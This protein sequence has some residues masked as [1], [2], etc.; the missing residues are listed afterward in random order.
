M[1]QAELTVG[2]VADRSGVPISTLHF[3]ERKGLIAPARDGSNRRLYPRE[4][5]RR[6]AVIKI[7]QRSGIP[8]SEIAD[9]LTTLP[10]ERTPTTSD[11]KRL[12]EKWHDRLSERIDALT[13]L[14]DKMS[15]CIGCGCLSVQRC[16]LMNEGDYLS[17][18]GPGARLLS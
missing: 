17:T 2:Q 12:S 10:R 1:M 11:W 9:A 16:P 13:A 8:L 6:V 5:L 7:A 14:R 4:I 15:M 3:Y 18:Q